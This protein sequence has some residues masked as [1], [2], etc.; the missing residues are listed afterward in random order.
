MRWVVRILFGLNVLYQILVG[1]LSL[2][3]PGMTIG[4]YGGGA[5][6]QQVLLLQA[7]LRLLG[8]YIVFGAVVSAVIA[9]RPDRH[10]VLLPLMAIL[11]VL[12]MAAWGLGMATGQVGISQAGLDL[13]V[14]LLILVVAMVYYPRA[15]RASTAGARPA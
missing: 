14:Q 11:A 8:G 7:V 15:R 6:D 4:L 3:A 2:A 5:S 10:P 12:T 9:A 1:L 13:V